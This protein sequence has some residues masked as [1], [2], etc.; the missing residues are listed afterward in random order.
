MTNFL[1]TDFVILLL[2][3]TRIISAF[4]S[5]P[6]FSHKAIPVIPRIFIAFV[7]AYVIFSM[8]DKS[9]VAVELNLWFIASNV[10]KEVLTGLIIGYSLNLLFYGLS[11]AGSLIGFDMGLAAASIM[12][13]LEETDN[14]V[15][16]EII[17]F[18]AM[19]VFFLV[20]GHHYVIKALYASF[21]IVPIGKYVIN[22]SV[23]N[24]LIKY[25]AS[26]FII[27]VKIA[28]PIL[29]SYFLIHIA[30]GIVARV[31]PQMQV[32]FVTQPLKIGLGLVL[33]SFTVPIYVYVLKGLL[34]MYEDNLYQLIKA[35]GS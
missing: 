35:M 6:V 34:S 1:V 26:V 29:V 23:Y 11:F 33:L 3:F 21:T 10:F 12:N 25:S 14:N 17:Y 20:N 9:T 19:L 8:I 15:I 5:A 18:L 24:L 22:E 2:I 16:G 31:I 7:I 32:F 4:S 30:E 13:P 27:A 28:A